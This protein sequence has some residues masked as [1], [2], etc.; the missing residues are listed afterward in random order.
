MA[1]ASLT[2]TYIA[3]TLAKASEVNQ[4]FTDLLGFLNTEVIQRDASVAFTA[5]PSGPGTD[6]TAA[7]QLA[8]KDYVDKLGVQTQDRRTSNGVQIAPGG[9]FD[10]SNTPLLVAGRWYSVHTHCRYQVIS[11]GNYAVVLKRAGVIVAEIEHLFSASAGQ[12]GH[13]D[14]QYIFQEGV[15]GSFNYTLGPSAGSSGNM[16]LLR[17]ATNPGTLTVWDLGP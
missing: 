15:G 5:V 10:F 6:P 7:N 3:G 1:T 8:R 12:D 9:I 4:N 2:H 14:S 13:I 11:A 16:Q 17:S